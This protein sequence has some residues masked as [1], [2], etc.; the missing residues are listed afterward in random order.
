MD[1]VE[2]LTCLWCGTAGRFDERTV[3]IE[4]GHEGQP[5]LVIHHADLCSSCLARAKEW[6]DSLYDTV[7]R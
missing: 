5:A 7:D 3:C 4:P 6:W 2:E 1:A